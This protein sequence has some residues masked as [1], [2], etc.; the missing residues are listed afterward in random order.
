ME[1][2]LTKEN[3]RKQ[4]GGRF[5]S[6]FTACAKCHIGLMMLI[7][8]IEGEPDKLKAVVNGSFALAQRM[9]QLHHMA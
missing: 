2:R 9:E 3:S 6:N 8:L 4:Q 1:E 5:A 7:P